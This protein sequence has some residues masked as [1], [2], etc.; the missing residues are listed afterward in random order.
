MLHSSKMPSTAP[1][2]VA[3]MRRAIHP[4]DRG[5]TVLMCKALPTLH[6]AKQEGIMKEA[7]S[8]QWKGLKR[9]RG[10]ENWHFFKFAVCFF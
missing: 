6:A 2:S 3:M 7:F 9:R 1:A 8:S 5:G 10:R 4:R